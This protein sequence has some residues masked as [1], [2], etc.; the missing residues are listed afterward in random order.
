M[1]S[2]TT[3]SAVAV[4]RSE[5]CATPGCSSTP[6]PAPA[7]ATAAAAAAS[8]RRREDRSPLP[9]DRMRVDSS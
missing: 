3:R 6:T 2:S 5:G 1:T 4:V 7:S 8:A 9:E